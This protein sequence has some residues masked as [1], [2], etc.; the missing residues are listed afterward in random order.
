MKSKARQELD[1]DRDEILKLFGNRCAVCGRPSTTIHEII[2]I[3]HGKSALS[4]DNR[5]VLCNFHHDWAHRVGTN[6]ST[7]V[8]QV[9]RQAYLTRYQ[10]EQ[11]L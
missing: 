8:L 6:N 11:N 4:I 5:I 1:N 9:I 7:T 2:P 10:N 3:S